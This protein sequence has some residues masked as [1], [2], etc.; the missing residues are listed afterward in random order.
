[1]FWGCEMDW[2]DSESGQSVSFDIDSGTQSGS[3]FRLRVCLLAILV[4]LANILHTKS[5]NFAVQ[6]ISQ[7]HRILTTATLQNNE[8]AIIHIELHYIHFTYLRKIHHN[9]ILSCPCESS[10]WPPSK[11]LPTKILCPFHASM[12]IFP[13][14]LKV[15]L[16]STITPTTATHILLNFV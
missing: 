7:I 6:D 12:S 9:V 5:I 4:I 11:R 14:S 13:S 1:M 2:T 3:I 10:K 8:L 16:P 15:I